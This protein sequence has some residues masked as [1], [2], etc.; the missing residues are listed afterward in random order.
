[1]VFE[2]NLKAA[3]AFNRFFICIFFLICFAYSSI[4]CVTTKIYIILTSVS[5]SQI[6]LILFIILLWSTILNL[7]TLLC[8]ATWTRNFTTSKTCI[9]F[10][11]LTVKLS[12]RKSAD[13]RIFRIKKKFR[14]CKNLIFHFKI[15]E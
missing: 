6:T 7:M 8:S 1:M 14:N 15:I 12:K 2:Q 10:S 4:L 13:F 11:S 9:N 3:F 5:I